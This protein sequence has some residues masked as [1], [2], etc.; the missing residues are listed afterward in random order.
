M[1]PPQL[2]PLGVARRA[3]ENYL[4]DNFDIDRS[5]LNA[6]GFGQTRRYA[7]NT[8][9]EGQQEN[10]RVNVIINYPN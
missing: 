10:R 8:S 4:V 5:R 6:Q 3:M 2:H 9:R 7:Y 1:H